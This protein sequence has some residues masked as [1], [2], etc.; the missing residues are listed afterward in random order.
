MALLNSTMK[1]KWIA[2][3]LLVM[4]MASRTNAQSNEAVQLALNIEKLAQLKSILE[5]LKKGYDIVFTGY[6]TVKNISEGNFSMHKLF[7]DGLMEVSP[8]VKKYHKVAG[9]IKYQLTLVKEYKSAFNRFKSI[10]WFSP[11]EITYLGRV[12][13]NLF[14]SSLQN[15]DELATVITANKLR[16][17]DDE[18]LA[19][20]DEIHKD[21]EHK[22]NFLRHFNKEAHFLAVQRLREQKEVDVMKELYNIK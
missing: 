10:N 18:R 12:Y 16:M 14:K 19:A 13:D 17:G 2:V 5:N 22:I 7:L 15:L 9:I 4:V 20:I 8:A 11:D 6:N 1:K 21:M 3:M